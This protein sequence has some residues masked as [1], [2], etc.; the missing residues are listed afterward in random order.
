MQESAGRSAL[1]R[2]D[3]ALGATVR[4][5]DRIEEFITSLLLITVVSINAVEVFMRTVLNSSFAWVY[6][7]NLLIASW[8]YFIGICLVYYRKRDI[9]IEIVD[10]LIS[11]DGLRAYTAILNIVIVVILLVIIYYGWILMGVQSRTKTLGVGI[12][13]HYF[14][15][16]VVI[17]AVSMILI[18]VNQSLA[19][20]LERR[21]RP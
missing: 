10:R 17:G 19:L 8:M 12:P 15:M 14:S 21:P 18:V 2:V 1:V 20:W 6:E 16:P 5:I 11:K 7:V 13:N 9:F 4:A 3:D